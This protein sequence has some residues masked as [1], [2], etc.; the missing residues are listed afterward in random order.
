MKSIW[1]NISIKYVKGHFKVKKIKEDP[2][3]Y[4]INQCDN[5]AKIVQYRLE[6]GEILSNL[7]QFGA[8]ATLHNEIFSNRIITEQV[9]LIDTIEIKESYTERQVGTHH[10]LVNK[11][12]RN[13]FH[14]ESS[15]AFLKRIATVNHYGTRNKQI[16]Q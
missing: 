10:Y 7:N 3:P 1:T 12:V 4:L 5:K 2:L 11:A 9:R 13:I 6:R 14:S 15:A 16:N 8:Y